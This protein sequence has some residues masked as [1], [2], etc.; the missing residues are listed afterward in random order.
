MYIV[1]CTVGCGCRLHSQRNQKM[2]RNK[3]KAV[4]IRSMK[5]N[6]LKFLL[7]LVAYWIWMKR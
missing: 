3:M 6:S 2:R 4:V 1:N 5:R 7:R